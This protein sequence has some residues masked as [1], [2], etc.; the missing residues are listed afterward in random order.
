[1]KNQL[2]KLA[3]L[4][5]LILF[6]TSCL[7]EP[8]Y[9]SSDPVEKNMNNIEVS[10]N[11]S[12]ETSK[13]VS[14]ILSAISKNPELSSKISIYNGNPEEGGD[15]IVNCGVT[16]ETSFEYEIQVPSYL[17]T[18]YLS[19]DFP[20]GK[21]I[22]DSVYANNFIEYTFEEGSLTT[23]S[24]AIVS[25]SAPASPDCSSGCDETITATSGNIVIDG[26]KTYCMPGN[27]TGG[28]TF[29][30]AG[31]TLKICG[32]AIL[33]YINF[34]GSPSVKIE[35]TTS[36][37]LQ[38]SNINLNKENYE[39]D[40]WG[41]FTCS[42]NFSPNGIFK[43]YGV[44]NISS[45]YNVNSGGTLI[46]TNS[47]NISGNFNNN[48][49]VENSGTLKVSGSFNN[50]N[51]AAFI[52]NCQ[53]IVTGNI[54]QSDRLINSGYIYAGGRFTVNSNSTNEMTDGALVVA[55]DLIVNSH[56]SGEGSIYSVFSISNTTNIN[57]SGSV[58]GKIDICDKNGI[59][60]NNGTV[61]ASVTYCEASVTT[62]ECNPGFTPPIKD[63]DNDGVAD[64]QDAAPDDAGSAYQSYFP[65]K[66]NTATLMFEDLWPSKGDY[67]FN[68]LVAS[69]QGTYVT[70]SSNKVVKLIFTINIKAVGA[71]YKNGL[72]VQLDNIVPSEVSSVTGTIRKSG[73]S[74]NL[75]SNGTEANQSKA[76]IIA[77]ENIENV[78]TRPGG[79]MFNTVNNGYVG[80]S[81]E[82]T[83]T[84]SF[85]NSPLSLDKLSSSSFNFFL[86]KN[87]DRGTEIHLANRKPTNL[88]TYEFG[89]L[90]DT[91]SPTNGRYYKT[92][93]NLPWGLL[94]LE[95]FKYP[96]EK[97]AI[98]SAYSKFADWAESNGTSSKNWY[99]SPNPS[100]VW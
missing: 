49:H 47:L 44:A 24:A 63:S 55:T 78:L 23:K 27:F 58:T 28:I 76:V 11:F 26:G 46:N 36:G 15:L 13:N 5:I 39:I 53:F 84:I 100:E 30:N 74:I 61:D 35:I 20:D 29:Q 45:E 59:E 88:M 80:T 9:T 34:N 38:S 14:F 60:N 21:S 90:N 79:S 82:V 10:E 72:G 56:I 31:G 12:W 57:G 95:P 93:N 83:V 22:L 2:S 87:Q 32:N 19:C 94:I 48:A 89:T 70:N 71:S 67:D 65:S 7:K 75:N 52:N 42:G 41:V 99:K 4:P 69:L 37:T 66:N 92:E 50:N 77:I 73:S 54:N 43:N 68:D 8:D 6:F 51:K 17:T 64:T 81:N 3:L 18:L 25:G 85:E 16:N 86:I 33:S 96:L 1:M 62:N 40:N 98:T 91:S 97:T